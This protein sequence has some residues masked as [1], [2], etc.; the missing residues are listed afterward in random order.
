MKDAFKFWILASALV[1]FACFPASLKAASLSG[2][3][4]A[5]VGRL[6]TV[7]SDVKGDWLIYPPDGADLAKDSDEQTL[8]SLED[9]CDFHNNEYVHHTTDSMGHSYYVS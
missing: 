8:Y 4:R 9:C 6:Q 1:F 5:E 3:Q 7:K 2:P